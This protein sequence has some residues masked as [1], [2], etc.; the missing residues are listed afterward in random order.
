[1]KKKKTIQQ[2]RGQSL[3]LVALAMVGLMAFAGLALDGGLAYATRRVA[4]NAADSGAIAGSHELHRQK[5]EDGSNANQI[6]Q[7]KILSA[8]HKVVESH[9]VPD[10]DGIPGNHINENVRAFFVSRGSSSNNCSGSFD[11]NYQ[12]LCEFNADRPCNRNDVFDDAVGI[13][14]EVEM[15]FQPMFAG[16][17]GWGEIEI[18]NRA[19]NF[20]QRTAA[21]I[22]AGD[23][24]YNGDTWAI[25]ATNFARTSG[26]STFI[27][28][29]PVFQPP[30]GFAFANVHSQGSFTV[31]N[32]HDPIMG[33]V[34]YC[35]DCNNCFNAALRPEQRQY[36]INLTDYTDFRDLAV[37]HAISDSLVFN[38]NL[39]RGNPI[40]GLPDFL[41]SGIWHITGDLL[42]PQGTM[43]VA[44]NSFVYVEGNVNIN[45]FLVATSFSIIS[46]GIITIN[47]TFQNGAPY[48]RFVNDAAFQGNSAVLWSNST[49]NNAINISGNISNVSTV[50]PNNGSDIRGAVMAPNSSVNVNANQ[51]N[52]M[53]RGSVIANTVQINSSATT[54]AQTRILYNGNYFPEQPDR[55]ELLK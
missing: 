9:D 26:P 28:V 10:T 37:Q 38:G 34:T 22:N 16:F 20:E 3:V 29:D 33:Q 55:I 49:N 7:R 45:G 51:I 14:I 35:A 4:Q 27:G 2:E 53:I 13:S 6:D 42:V 36:N 30:V 11:I 19:T 23:S 17:M 25:F 15:P 21:I 44:R 46:D 47:G 43:L 24:G 48:P 54:G 18:S 50:L 8:I 31:G 41:E 32:N 12:E 52:T 40:S 39:V 5:W 1:M